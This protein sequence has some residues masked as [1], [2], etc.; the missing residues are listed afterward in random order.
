LNRSWLKYSA[1]IPL[2]NMLY[3]FHDNFINHY[4]NYDSIGTG[5]ETN[6]I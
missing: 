2:N 6:V 5:L 3:T 1:G 4:P